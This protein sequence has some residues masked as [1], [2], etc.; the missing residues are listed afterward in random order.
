LPLHF[1]DVEQVGV[2]VVALM[3]EP[4][5]QQHSARKKEEKEKE[6]IRTG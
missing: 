2:P 6:G 4:A 3:V 1:F 5:E